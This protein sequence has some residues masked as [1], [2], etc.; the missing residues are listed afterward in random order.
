M[1]ETTGTPLS[2]DHKKLFR[3]VLGKTPVIALG[4]GGMGRTGRPETIEDLYTA[5]TNIVGC[6]KFTMESESKARNGLNEINEDLEAAGRVLARMGIGKDD[7]RAAF[8][9]VLAAV[10]IRHEF[11]EAD[12]RQIA[13][14]HGVTL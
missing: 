6:L 7:V 14:K 5:L 8:K 13:E 10:Q 1:A 9:S 2:A 4:G 3:E 11:T 12:V